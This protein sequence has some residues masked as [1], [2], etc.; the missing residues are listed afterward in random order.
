MM[1]F[2]SDAWDGEES[3]VQEEDE[4]HNAGWTREIAVCEFR[5]TIKQ[6]VLDF[7]SL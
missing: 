4:D 5:E 1:I 6:R 3:V 2:V 7:N